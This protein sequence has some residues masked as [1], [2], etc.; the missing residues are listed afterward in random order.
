VQLIIDLKKDYKK[1]GIVVTHD[2]DTAEKVGDDI[3]LLKNG[4]INKLKK[5]GKEVYN[6]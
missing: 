5:I 4:K 6:G 3:Y 1:I 2:L